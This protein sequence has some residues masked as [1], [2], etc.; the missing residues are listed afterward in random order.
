MKTILIAFGALLVLSAV[1]IVIVRMPPH[2]SQRAHAESPPDSIV[3][4]TEPLSFIPAKKLTSRALYAAFNTGFLRIEKPMDAYRY[5]NLQLYPIYATPGFLEFH[6]N[7][8]PYMSLLEALKQH[9][10]LISEL[11]DGSDVNTLYAENISCDTIIILGGEVIRGGK[12]DRMIARDF[13]LLPGRGKM[14]ISVFCVEHD[15]W[16]SEEEIALFDMTV[17]IAPNS[18]RDATQSP[19]AQERVWEEVAELNMAYDVKEETGALAFAIADEDMK[20]N[21]QPYLDELQNIVWPIDVV[22]VIA[23]MD[24]EVVGCDIFAQHDLFVRYYANLLKSYCGNIHE[25]KYEPNLPFREVQA[26]FQRVFKS[27][28]DLGTHLLDHGTQ[29]KN[30]RYRIHAAVY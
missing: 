24:N 20:D 5:N 18:V 6:K 17:G 15:R 28:K 3:K 16:T 26:F 29:L 13:M 23:V 12:Q 22:G 21:L 14:N 4:L 25:A 11:G 27:E 8:G 19:V 9:K 10:L 7:L 30:G 1:I 2:F